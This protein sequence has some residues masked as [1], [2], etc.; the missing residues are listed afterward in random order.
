MIPISILSFLIPAPRPWE[1]FQFDSVE[2]EYDSAKINLIP[3]EMIPGRRLENDSNLIPERMISILGG[4]ILILAG[5]IPAAPP[6]K[7]F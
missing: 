4:L 3:A 1:L 6:A 5:M 7:W 2:N